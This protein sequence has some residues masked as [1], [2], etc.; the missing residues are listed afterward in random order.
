ML[1]HYTWLVQ[2]VAVLELICQGRSISL[3]THHSATPLPS[4]Q[5][6]DPHHITQHSHTLTS[7]VPPS[8]IAP[9]LCLHCTVYTASTCSVTCCILHS[10]YASLNC[11]TPLSQPH[12]TETQWYTLFTSLALLH[13]LH[14][15]HLH[16]PLT[17]YT[18]DTQWYF[19]SASHSTTLCTPSATW[20]TRHRGTVHW[21]LT[22]PP[23]ALPTNQLQCSHSPFHDFQVA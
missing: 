23:L 5:L 16:C 4:F 12:N 3:S 20:T 1:K 14:S 10:S 17:I 21:S 19:M 13:S 15:I 2:L 18:T 6:Q 8:L 22:D 11:S 9:S 7:C